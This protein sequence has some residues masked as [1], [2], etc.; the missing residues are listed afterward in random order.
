MFS[1]AEPEN[2]GASCDTQAKR[3]RTATGSASRTSTP[4]TDTTPACG[5]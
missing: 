4:S 2:S 3:S 1:L 5:S